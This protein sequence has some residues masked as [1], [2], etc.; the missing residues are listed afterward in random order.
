MGFKLGCSQKEQLVHVP[1]LW[2]HGLGNGIKGGG[3]ALQ[4]SKPST[5]VEHVKAANFRHVKKITDVKVKKSCFNLRESEHS[6][7]LP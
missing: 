5:Q 7:P 6:H 4:C 2:L 1:K 3:P